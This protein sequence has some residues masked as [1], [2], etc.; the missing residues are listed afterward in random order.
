MATPTSGTQQLNNALK[1]VERVGRIVTEVLSSFVGPLALAYGAAFTFLG[2]MGRVLGASRLVSAALREWA[3][4]QVY[5]PQ[6]DRLLGSLAAAQQRLRM[7]SELSKG[8]F[9]FDDLAQA[10]KALEVFTR[11]AL[12]SKDGME[13]VMDAAAVGNTSTAE[14]SRTIGQLYD[15]IANHRP[16]DGYMQ[17][18]R[19]MGVVSSMTADEITNLSYSGASSAQIWNAVENALRKNKGS[20][21]AL[22]NTIA[23]LEATLG[24][25]RADELGKIGQM[26]EE[27]KMA[28][29]RAAIG[30]VQLLG[31]VLRDVLAPVAALYNGFSKMT[32][33]FVNW[34]NSIPGLQS[35]LKAVIGFVLLLSAALASKALIEVVGILVRMSGILTALAGKSGVFQVIGAGMGV[36]LRQALRLL[37]PIG[38]IVAGLEALLAL[39]GQYGSDSS[40]S[41]AQKKLADEVRQT[42]AA[43]KEQIENL[44]SGKVEAEAKG[45]ILA[46]AAANTEAAH[47]IAVD[48][49][50][51]AEKQR[52]S[53]AATDI[54][55][56]AGVGAILGAQLGMLAGPGGALVGG[57]VGG[58]AGG[59]Y[60]AYSHN[61]NVAEAEKQSKDAREAEEASIRTFVE[62]MNAKPKE[63]PADYLNNPYF[64]EMQA[65]S[66]QTLNDL[67]KKYQ[68]LSPE[69]KA[70]K[71]GAEIRT[72]MREEQQKF[73]RDNKELAFNKYMEAATTQANLRQA[74][75]LRTGDKAMVKEGDKISD[76]AFAAKRMKELVETFKFDPKEAKGM[77]DGELLQ[78]QADRERERNPVVASGR[79]RLGF[80]QGEAAGGSTEEARILK[81]MLTIMESQRGS[82]YQIP[83]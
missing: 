67:A 53:S 48:S 38:L 10:N 39:T 5:T 11:G 47:K 45:G 6:F 80:A 55:G 42:N 46:D 73:S 12:S 20:A 34:L 24:N 77:V 43:I 57:L 21:D 22:K 83:P 23:G 51:N 31:P 7:I 1:G 56:S 74:I 40:M 50:A 4:I 18:L 17:Q 14:M 44:K 2:V 28:G 82:G 32:E 52:K 35:A 72:Q 15:Q 30:L 63:K 26:F 64:Q 78:R 75:G 69:Q 41:G 79:A 81:K 58:L 66:Q 76:E 62:A 36:M 9:K 68:A 60:G 54:L 3:R 33:K 19:E 29:L 37:G 59:A 71:E 25:V 49:A 16:I 65:K 61:Q 70:G 8:A 13:L 27:G